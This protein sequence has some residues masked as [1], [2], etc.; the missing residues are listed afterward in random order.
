MVG[1]QTTFFQFDLHSVVDGSETRRQ[2]QL[3]FGSLSHYL[4][5]FIHP[6]WLSRQ[7]SEPSTVGTTSM[8][9]LMILLPPLMGISSPHSLFQAIP[10]IS[11]GCSD[12]PNLPLSGELFRVFFQF[13]SHFDLHFVFQKD[14]FKKT[15]KRDSSSLGKI[16]CE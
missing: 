12:A 10:L 13:R 7:I 3:S 16:C 2:N 6:R 11:L 9:G 1:S 15:N 8:M 14:Y 4:H 5:G